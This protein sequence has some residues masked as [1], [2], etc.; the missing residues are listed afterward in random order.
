MAASNR[1]NFDHTACYRD[2]VHENSKAG[3]H[4][5]RREGPA[6]RS[7]H[8]YAVRNEPT[9]D[10]APANLG[11]QQHAEGLEPRHHRAA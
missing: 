3:R 9:V 6:S 4:W 5:C 10:A 1:V 11:P 7:G 8:V 2:N